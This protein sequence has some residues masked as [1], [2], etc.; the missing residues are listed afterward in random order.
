MM[1]FSSSSTLKTIVDQRLIN[2]RTTLRHCEMRL[3]GVHVSQKEVGMAEVVTLD[4]KQ[5]SIALQKGRLER[6][7]RDFGA[8]Y[9]MSFPRELIPALQERI[10]EAQLALSPMRHSPQLKAKLAEI[11]VQ[12][13]V[14]QKKYGEDLGATGAKFR[15]NMFWEVLGDMPWDLVR[16]GFSEYVKTE[17][18]FPAP[19]NIR[20]LAAREWHRR[21]TR[22]AELERLESLEPPVEERKMTREEREH[23]DRQWKRLVEVF[24]PPM[25]APAPEPMPIPQAAPGDMARR[26]GV[27]PEEQTQQEAGVL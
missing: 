6:L 24:E 20:K 15:V 3:N 10:R 1:R 4:G 26:M 14:C 12:L 16:Q 18:D 2:T 8:A 11:L 17:A 27:I 9:L 25:A 13:Y 23:Y 22:L 21:K 7:L 5:S 19:A